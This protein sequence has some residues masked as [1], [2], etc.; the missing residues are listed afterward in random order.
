MIS[1]DNRD[2]A[3]PAQPQEFNLERISRLIS[4]LEQEVATAPENHPKV[5]V[6][7]D[8]IGTLK[9]VLAASDSEETVVREKLH[10]VHSTFQDVTARVE[11]EV[12]K[13]S[14]YIAEIGRILGLV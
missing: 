6:L 3:S 14:P 2:S 9:Q 1:N 11:S 12:L 10:T 7:K 8:E 13:D 4:A 5:Q